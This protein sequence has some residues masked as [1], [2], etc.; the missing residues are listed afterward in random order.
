MAGLS[1]SEIRRVGIAAK[2]CASACS[3]I[4]RHPILFIL[5][6]KIRLW[7]KSE[8]LRVAVRNGDADA[9]SGEMILP[10]V[11]CV[12]DRV[13]LEV[14]PTE[15]L[16]CRVCGGAVDGSTGTGTGS[17]PADPILELA[18]TCSIIKPIGLGI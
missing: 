8:N 16:R 12:W 7:Y 5:G 10:I 15:P 2:Y 11:P 18:T 13:S 17:I 6:G 1:L 14:R 4:D 9:W 3:R